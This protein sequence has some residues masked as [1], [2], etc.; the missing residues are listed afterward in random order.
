MSL[1]FSILFRN[2]QTGEN[3]DRCYMCLTQLCFS[4]YAFELEKSSIRKTKLN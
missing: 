4:R 2:L 1:Q 3:M